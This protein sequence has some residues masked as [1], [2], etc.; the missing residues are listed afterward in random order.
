MNKQ[1]RKAI[2]TRTRLLN[3][4]RKFNSP[5]SQL[6]YKRQHSY[7]VKLVKISKKDFYNNFKVKK[8]TDNK[9]FWKTDKVLKDG[10][11]VLVED[12]KLITA[13]TD[14]AEIFKDHFETIVESLHIER[15]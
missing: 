7:C 4:L 6:A 14:L 11:I 2:M 8:V 1:L 9:Y 12:D 13:D 5:E 10:K 3:Q 15:P